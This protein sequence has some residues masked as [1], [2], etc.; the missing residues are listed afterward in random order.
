VILMSAGL[1]ATPAWIPQA[2][3]VTARFRGVSAVNDRVVWASGAN[4]TI[5]RTAD[6]GRTW[7]GLT[8]TG[9][10]ALDFRDID[11][12]DERTAY[13]LSIGSGP[14][15]RI[16]KT[17]DAGANW[18]LQFTNSDEKA[19]F[20]A[21]AFWDAERGLAF[22]DSVD[23]NFVILSTSDGGRTWSRV[24]QNALPAAVAGEGAFAASGT[25]VAMF[26]KSDVWIGTTAGR[27]LH[28]VDAGRNWSI[29]PAG[30]ATGDATGIFS[31]AFRDARHGIVVGG[32]YRKEA[33]AVDNAATTSDGGKTWTPIK[34]LS[35]FRSVVTYLP[36][37]ATVSLV[38]VGPSGADFSADDGRTWTPIP[39][40]GFHA[41]SAAPGGSLGWAV[42][43]GGRISQLRW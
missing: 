13:A 20:D 1:L 17:T 15:S 10:E 39:G 35:G 18:S 27:V 41:F 11:A 26:G 2:S 7:Q 4:G 19:F 5:V 25:N 12:V 34:G 40:D 37:A 30:V 43:E 28:S 9:A 14:A 36:R 6:G 8:V 38:A 3:G 32:N 24:P 29:A 31:I 42:G 22:S 33:E 23:G 21:M 16:Y